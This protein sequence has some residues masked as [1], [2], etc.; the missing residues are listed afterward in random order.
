LREV[1]RVPVF[2]L[3]WFAATLDGVRACVSGELSLP[4]PGLLIR[5]LPRHSRSG[6][7]CWSTGP[8]Y[9]LG[10]AAAVWVF[11]SALAGPAG[12]ARDI[13]AIIPRV[14]VHHARMDHA[15]G[16]PMGR[17]AVFRAVDLA[18]SK[19]GATVAW[20]AGRRDLPTVLAGTGIAATGDHAPGVRTIHGSRGSARASTATAVPV[21]RAFGPAPGRRTR[22]FLR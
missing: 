4:S 6:G 11:P 3:S 1:V 15:T 19:S 7:G 22:R 16:R 2:A 17:T 9:G 13:P 12:V 21:C 20:R 14:N 5:S 8:G 18:T 10:S